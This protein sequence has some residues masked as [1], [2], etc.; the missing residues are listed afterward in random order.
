MLL[1]GGTLLVGAT[2]QCLHAPR[3]P[4]NSPFLLARFQNIHFMCNLPKSTLIAANSPNSPSFLVETM[5]KVDD[6]RDYDDAVRAKKECWPGWELLLSQ[7]QWILQLGGFLGPVLSLQ[8][9]PRGHTAPKRSYIF[10]LTHPLL[11]LF[12]NGNMNSKFWIRFG[13][14]CS[15]LGNFFNLCKKNLC[16]IFVLISLPYISVAG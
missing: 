11:R 10:L 4:T 8:F 9:V 16:V 6:G 12:R 7:I 2:F 5:T 13:W 15:F 14:G 3:W 1:I